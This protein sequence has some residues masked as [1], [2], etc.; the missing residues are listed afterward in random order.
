MSLVVM[1][2]ATPALAAQDTVSVNFASTS[3]APTYRASGIIY[4]LT[5]DGSGPPDRFITDIKLRFVRAGGA[6]LD[7]P[8]G[9]VAGRYDRR[10]RS[11]LAQYRRTVALGGTFVILPH[12]LWGAD[13]TTSPTFP[14]DNGD[15]S[16]FDRFLERLIAD[17]QASGMNPQWDIWNEPDWGSFWGR[18]QDQYLQMWRRAFQRI[19]AAFP[20]AVIVGPST[21]YQPAP[22]NG[23]WARFLDFAKANNVVPDVIS[24]H[25]L[26]T[27]VDPAIN[28]TYA[29]QLLSSRGLA[30]RQY[31][32]NEYGTPEEQTPGRSAWY[33]ARMERAGIDGLRAN[34][35]S[36][37]GL[38]D[39]LAS[40]L[41]RNGSGYQP[42]GDWFA[43]QS[44]AAM[45]G[46]TVAVTRGNLIDGYATKDNGR[47]AVLLGNHG[48]TGDITVNLN[49]LDTTGLVAGGAIR[50]VLERVPQ[51]NGGASSGRVV[52]SDRSIAVSNNA[53]SLTVP[54]SNADDAYALTLYPA[55][56]GPDP[57]PPG[58]R[59]FTSTAVNQNGGNC[60]DVP[61]GGTEDGVKLIQW[62][63]N[64]GG[65]Q[66]FA[67]IP[68]A[69][70]SG[71]Y[72]IGTAAG[73]CVDV[74]EI[75]TA[76]NAAIHQWTCHGGDNQKWQ[77]TPV[78][79]AGTDK[80]FTLMAVHSGKCI[81]PAGG[82]SASNTGLVQLPCT[83]ARSMVWR[84]PN[85]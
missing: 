7:I 28:K 50:A 3:G 51:G 60:M 46:T 45:T 25:S 30:L 22:D 70:T 66:S 63:C 1:A 79:I 41:V 15:W 64:G 67:F 62:T 13:G 52:V 84:L 81:V 37:Q 54:W 11:T 36:Q 43:Y 18:S 82:S 47:A 4:G 29:D 68:V 5:E 57:N 35:G 76:D 38:H 48:V 19:R 39:N 65:N 32:I 61:A 49:R 85:Y 26:N 72:T 8:G 21:A 10:W 44:Y 78:S 17:A 34:W 12:D 55:T 56:G 2:P 74:S 9:W 33:I 69:G 75:S 71:Q 42:R 16:N 73:K 24:W 31:Q 27:G 40:L 59:T 53:A 77:L 6:Q 58:P 83:S 20:N 23:W 80:T 14:G